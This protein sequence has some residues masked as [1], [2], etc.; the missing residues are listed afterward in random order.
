MLFPCGGHPGRI[1]VDEDRTSGQ[2]LIAST[3]VPLYRTGCA[4]ASRTTS[5]RLL[6]ESLN[7][8]LSMGDNYSTTYA[9]A[10]NERSSS[11]LPT[12]EPGNILV[13][14]SPMCYV[15]EVSSNV[16]VDGKS[17][18]GGGTLRPL[19]PFNSAHVA[20]LVKHERI[21]KRA[22]RGVEGALDRRELAPGYLELHRDVFREEQRNLYTRG[23]RTVGLYSNLDHLFSAARFHQ[24]PWTQSSGFFGDDQGSC[25]RRMFAAESWY[26]HGPKSETRFVGRP[27]CQI[28][29]TL[30]QDRLQQ[31]CRTALLQQYSRAARE[32][33]WRVLHRTFGF[34]PKR[35]KQHKRS[36]LAQWKQLYCTPIANRHT[37][38]LYTRRK[39]YRLSICPVSG[40]V[41]RIRGRPNSVSFGAAKSLVRSSRKRNPLVSPSV[42]HFLNKHRSFRSGIKKKSP[43]LATAITKT[44]EKTTAF[45]QKRQIDFPTITK[46]CERQ[47]Q[48]ASVTEIGAP[49]DSNRFVG[50]RP[51]VWE[52]D[53]LNE[54][55]KKLKDPHTAS[56]TLQ[57]REQKAWWI[58]KRTRRLLQVARRHMN[59]EYVE[60]LRFL[61][62]QTA[63]KTAKGVINIQT[64]LE[65]MGRPA[66][67]MNVILVGGSVGK[68]TVATKIAAALSS[69]GYR[70]G[71]FVAPHLA[72][73]RERI[74]VD[75]SLITKSECSGLVAA[76]RAVMRRLKSPM[77]SLFEWMTL[78]AVAHFHNHDCQ[79]IVLE[80]GC[81][82]REDKTIPTADPTTAVTSRSLRCLVLTSF[83]LSLPQRNFDKLLRHVLRYYPLMGFASFGVVCGPSAT[84]VFRFL[85][86]HIPR[87]GK[88][89]PLPSKATFLE[90]IP[91][92]TFL[93]EDTRIAESVF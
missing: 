49:V 41:R 24:H 86:A 74:S 20:E 48:G 55:L 4:T 66:E 75:G 28:S 11:K 47:L 31:V 77:P 40:Q 78:I 1:R 70:V 46:G 13:H 8:F 37:A 45:E 33:S 76:L 83:S 12:K 90:H 14:P 39:P 58:F 18:T 35:R 65:A 32:R 44:L 57:Q 71:L 6:E 89:Y 21:R 29:T 64:I 85:N 69:A 7:T 82:T 79:Y 60:T 42:I 87:F 52:E 38:S 61:Y 15:D 50:Y 17:S 72:T 73:F 27:G 67:R 92:E 19:E 36:V 25:R 68:T 88:R 26:R 16:V 3:K 56:L 43:A 59:A 5:L 91:R 2:L 93:E 84:D 51:A 22:E 62:N 9:H 23:G 81:P 80:M 54:D 10:W 53:A 30:C 63:R 34:V